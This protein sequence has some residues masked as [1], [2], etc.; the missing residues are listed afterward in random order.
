[1]GI[2]GMFSKKDKDGS[3]NKSNNNKKEEPN[4]FDALKELNVK[5]EE[6]PK[7][8]CKICK[9]TFKNGQMRFII[10]F[11]RLFEKT[12]RVPIMW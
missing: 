11:S 4:D 12:D 1:M 9:K 2:K 7:D 8:K 10:S 6:L 5:T 3:K